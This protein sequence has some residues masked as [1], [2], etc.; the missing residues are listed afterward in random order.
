MFQSRNDPLMT[1]IPA[2][3]GQLCG[4]YQP[5]VS[6]EPQTSVCVSV[7]SKVRKTGQLLCCY[8]VIFR[9]LISILDRFERDWFEKEVF[10]R[11]TVLIKDQ[12]NTCSNII[13][14]YAADLCKTINDR[15]FVSGKQKGCISSVFIES[16]AK[17]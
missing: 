17:L 5:S 10:S 6:C 2:P 13:V 8:Y 16:V 4:D 12:V 1:G 9:Y 3:Q 15:P 14:C 7:L 11:R